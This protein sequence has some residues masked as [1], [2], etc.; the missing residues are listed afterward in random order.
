MTVYF[1]KSETK[2]SQALKQAAKEAHSLN[3]NARES[4]HK[5]ASAFATSRQVSIQ[6][7]VYYSLPEFG[8]VNVVLILYILILT[9]LQNKYECVNHLKK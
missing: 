8:S 6:E 7:A 2:S 3:L 1:S 4:M 5:I 9:F